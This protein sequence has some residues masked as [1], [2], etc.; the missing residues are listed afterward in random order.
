MELLYLLLE[1]HSCNCPWQ[2]FTILVAKS[3]GF[4]LKMNACII[5]LEHAKYIMSHILASIVSD[6]E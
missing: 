1:L 4:G 2:V 5:F 3:L 6:E